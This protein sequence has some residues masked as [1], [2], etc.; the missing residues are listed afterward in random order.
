[1]AKVIK[2]SSVKETIKKPPTKKV[3][4]IKLKLEA[5]GTEYACEGETMLEALEKLP[6]VL[7]YTQVNTQGVLHFSDGKNKGSKLLYLRQLRMLLVNP[8]IRAGQAQQFEL[9]LKANETV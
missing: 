9:L 7:D 1:M 2:K 6:L 5:N 4:L 8:M 3:S